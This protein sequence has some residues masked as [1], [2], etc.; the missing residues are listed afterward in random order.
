[1]IR[2]R[3]QETDQMS[4]VYHGNYLTWLEMGRTDFIRERGFTYQ[5]LEGQ[6]VLLPV[7]EVQCR[8]IQPAKYDE[9]ILIHTFLS[10]LAGSKI[11]FDYEV[12]RKTDNS[13]LAKGMSK[14]LF[15][16]QHM[17]RINIKIRLPEVYERLNAKG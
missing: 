9:E 2:V 10:E 14:H 17:K 6:G 12:R 1:M 16:D 5:R 11:V 4:V 3:Y 15:T 8:Y 13:L 7:V